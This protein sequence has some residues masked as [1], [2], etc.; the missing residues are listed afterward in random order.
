MVLDVTVQ[1]TAEPAPTMVP[2]IELTAEPEPTAT[3]MVAPT[4]APTAEPTA[5]AVRLPGREL[6]TF[7]AGE[8]AWFTVDDDVMGGVSSS[9][10]NFDEPGVMHFSGNMSLDNNGGFSSVRSGWTAMDLSDADGILL[11]VQG[12][13]NVYRL[14]VRTETA[15]REVTYNAFFETTAGEWTVAFVPFEQMV[16]TIR[17]FVVD[18]GPVDRANIGSFGL[19][20]SDK[21]EGAF[22]LKVDWMRAVSLEEIQALQG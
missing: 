12:D 9:T 14:R 2:T 11:R 4:L 18:V 19:M 1:P 3:V 17:G 16:P 5:A 13:G 21:Q 22:E 6:F 20:L 10:V 8:P 15:G 7:A